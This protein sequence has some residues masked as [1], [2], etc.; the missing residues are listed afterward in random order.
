M[1][2][3]TA[4]PANAVAPGTTPAPP[5]VLIVEDSRVQAELLRRLI[6]DA[7][8]TVQ[9]A[10]NGA[11]GLALAAAQPPAA[12]VSD[13]NMPVMDGF[14][15]CQAMRQQPALATLPVIL[16]TSLADTQDV[17]RG[18]NAGAD[19]Y[20]TKPYD[21]GLLL[22]CLQ[23][24]LAQPPATRQAESRTPM[25]VSVGGQ[26][27]RV[28]PRNPQQVLNLLVSTYE[29]AVLQN[30]ELRLTQERLLALNEQLAASNRT[31]EA[32]YK[33]LRETQ[34]Q[35]V[36]SAKMASLGQLVAG[37]AHEINNPLAFV[38][39]HQ[40]TVARALTK[41]AGEAAT[42]LSADGAQQLHKAQSRLGDMSGGLERIRD[43]VLKLRTFSRLDE[44]QIKQINIDE[45]IDSVLTLLQYRLGTRIRVIRRF[46]AVKQLDCYPGPL[47][48]VLM[49]LLA[50]A[51]DAI[52]G[53]GEITI[54]TAAE[55]GL[56]RI[57]IADTGQG[58][59]EAVRE[60]IFEPFFTTKPVGQG[61]GLGLSISFGIIRDHGGTLKAFSKEGEGTQM[62]IHLPLNSRL[63]AVPALEES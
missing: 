5:A 58:M 24:L 45:A 62:I 25:P 47:N 17:I 4:P 39:N 41:V 34:S 15:M 30:R 40:D 33:E 11:E 20:V 38:M 56:L 12:V 37:V 49:N 31:L 42:Q 23:A 44:G 36:Q 6:A 27:H 43:L 35:L 26:L 29:S 51:I 8:Y 14:A 55:D 19:C 54:T 10:G 13:V 18:L 46:G 9:L 21:E 1:T 59:P 7:G 3:R 53:E 63:H 22:A 60:R 28:T 61:T 57:A 16:L 2:D 52:D 50:N 48:Q 32:A